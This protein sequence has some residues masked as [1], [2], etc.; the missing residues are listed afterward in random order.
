MATHSI[1]QHN[2]EIHEGLELWKKKVLLRKVYHSFYLEISKYLLRNQSGL[3]VE[4]GSGIGNLKSVFP[5][6]LATDIFQNPW[7]DQVETAY[8]LSFK[9]ESV[10][11]LILFDVFHHLQYP[12]TALSEL[13]R[14]LVPGGRLIIFEPCLSLL[15]Y[16]LYGVLHR[17]GVGRARDIVWSAP[18]GWT[19]SEN[20]YYA[21]QGNAS[22]IFLT[23][24]YEKEL[25]GWNVI[26]KKRYSALSYVGS[27]GYRGPQLYPSFMHSFMLQ[28]DKVAN[29]LP[30]LFATRL[31][32]VLEKRENTE[33]APL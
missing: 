10:K 11:N 15:G 13:Y 8:S 21:A 2:V 20:G 33:K 22:N 24:T 19:S 31:L 1:D 27:G 23:K 25:S 6:C 7:I 17:E 16:I 3:T 5:E 4:L 28:I 30:W 14:V 29:L 32:V 12:G 26:T 18:Q 9:N